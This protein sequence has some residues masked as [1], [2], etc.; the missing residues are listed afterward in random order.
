MPIVPN[1]GDSARVA[2]QTSNDIAVTRQLAV[3]VASAS[4]ELVMGVA[5][6]LG[7]SRFDPQPDRGPLPTVGKMPQ[8]PATAR[9]ADMRA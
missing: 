3:V 7:L 9:A 8:R 2:A 6:L 5:S 1:T 4:E